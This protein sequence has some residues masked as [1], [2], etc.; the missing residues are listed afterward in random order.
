MGDP[1]SHG[2][3]YQMVKSDLDNLPV[4]TGAQLHLD[5]GDPQISAHPH[6][7]PENNKASMR[8]MYIYKHI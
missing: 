8:I 7:K 5:L 3:Q 4:R 1:K 6:P 2:F